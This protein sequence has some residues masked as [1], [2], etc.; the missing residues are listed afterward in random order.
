MRSLLVTVVDSD[1]ANQL[2]YYQ[3]NVTRK[4]CGSNYNNMTA[5]EYHE[6]AVR[7]NRKLS[8]VKDTCYKS[9]VVSSCNLALMC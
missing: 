4:I 7:I 1:A 5:E 8:R 6:V 3:S 2:G 9:L